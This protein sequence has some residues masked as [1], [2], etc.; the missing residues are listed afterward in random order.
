MWQ[1]TKAVWAQTSWRGAAQ[2]DAPNAS[3][4]VHFHLAGRRS[5]QPAGGRTS[6]TK[7]QSCVHWF[8]TWVHHPALLSVYP[9]QS[10]TAIAKPNKCNG[11]LEEWAMRHWSP[12]SNLNVKLSNYAAALIPAFGSIYRLHDVWYPAGTHSVVSSWPKSTAGHLSVLSLTDQPSVY[13]LVSPCS[14]LPITL[15]QVS[16]CRHQLSPISHKLLARPERCKA[17]IFTALEAIGG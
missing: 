2:A 4:D 5:N 13:L 17:A 3:W 1:E 11:Y 7:C 14:L 12:R 6:S 16:Q 10:V 8:T 9:S 15:R